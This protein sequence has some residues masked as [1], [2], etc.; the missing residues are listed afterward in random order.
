[1]SK[2]IIVLNNK[3]IDFGEDCFTPL[4]DNK[5]FNI[6]TGEILSE[7]TLVNGIASFPND[8]DN[9]NYEFSFGAF[10][11][12][13]EK[14]H[15]T[16]YTHYY[17]TGVR[18]LKIICGFKPNFVFLNGTYLVGSGSNP[19]QVDVNKVYS[20]ISTINNEIAFNDNG[21]TLLGDP[22][23]LQY[24]VPF[25]ETQIGTNTWVQTYHSGQYDILAIK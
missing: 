23:D 11:K 25:K 18:D 12:E 10:K 6:K 21:F 1:M 24:N 5:I 22:Y 2:Q 9:F 14:S 17:G 7:G 20:S 13:I 16:Y 19:T 8:L 3:V 4:A 15:Q